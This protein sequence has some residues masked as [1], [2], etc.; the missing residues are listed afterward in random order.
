MTEKHSIKY[1]IEDKLLGLLPILH[2]VDNFPPRPEAKNILVDGPSFER[3]LY[4][5]EFFKNF[6]DFLKVQPFKLEELYA[7]LTFGTD[8]APIL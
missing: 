3:L 4:I 2:N 6:C 7:A 8:G 1:P 5:W